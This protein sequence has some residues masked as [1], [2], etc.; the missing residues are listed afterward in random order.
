LQNVE[1]VRLGEDIEGRDEHRAVMLALPQPF[2]ALQHAAGLDHIVVTKV[3]PVALEQIEQHEGV[4]G[5]H[6]ID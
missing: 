1:S 5:R 6:R 2:P 4:A 3:E